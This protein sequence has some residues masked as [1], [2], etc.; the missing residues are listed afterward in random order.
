[1]TINV[2]EALDSDTAVK[3]VVL[4]SSEGAYVSGIWQE[5]QKTSFKALASPQQP[6][7]EELMRLPEGQRDRDVRL[8]ICNKKLRTVDDLAGYKADVLVFQGIK[9]EALKVADWSVFG[10]TVAYCVQVNDD[11]E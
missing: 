3:I 11:V 8:F 9:Y 10:H 2:S 1:M 7:A 6:D 4:R 5:P